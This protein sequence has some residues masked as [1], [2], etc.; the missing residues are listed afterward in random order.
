MVTMRYIFF[1]FQWYLAYNELKARAVSM[2][3]IMTAEYVLYCHIL[4][5]YEV[6]ISLLV[7]YRIYT[8]ALKNYLFVSE[9]YNISLSTTI[10]VSHYTRIALYFSHDWAILLRLLLN[11]NMLI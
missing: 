3:S 9:Q 4:F 5:S 7:M 2:H 8:F 1:Y 11:I 10:E 6:F